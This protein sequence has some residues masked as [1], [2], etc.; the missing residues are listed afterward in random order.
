M[1][2]L[3]VLV[4]RDTYNE[5]KCLSKQVLLVY[6]KK[7]LFG[8][9]LPLCETTFNLVSIITSLLLISSEKFAIDKL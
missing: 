6:K 5:Y 4:E 7:K 3:D 9:I 8:K 2:E 1:K